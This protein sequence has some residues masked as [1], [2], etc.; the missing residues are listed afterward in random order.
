[1][2][3]RSFQWKINIRHKTWTNTWWRCESGPH[4]FVTRWL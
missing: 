4:E 1:M 3:N 2:R